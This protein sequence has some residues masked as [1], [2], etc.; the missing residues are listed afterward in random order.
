MSGV[1]PRGRLQF[2]S[3]IARVGWGFHT[4]VSMGFWLAQIRLKRGA[5]PDSNIEKCVLLTLGYD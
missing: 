1:A 2:L 3:I 5:S 4:D